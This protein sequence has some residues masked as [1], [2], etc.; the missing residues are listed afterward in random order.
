V[1]SGRAEEMV[2]RVIIDR[3]NSKENPIFGLFG[4][5]ILIF[6]QVVLICFYFQ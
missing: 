4:T 2:D 3:I 5:L 1:E 6:Y